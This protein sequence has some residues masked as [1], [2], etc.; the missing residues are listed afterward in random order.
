MA[1][2]RAPTPRAPLPG[3]SAARMK[4]RLS[5]CSRGRRTRAA[6]V[7]AIRSGACARASRM[8]AKR[9]A[10]AASGTRGP[11]EQSLD[12][13]GR[14][15]LGGTFAAAGDESPGCARKA[16]GPLE[17]PLLQEPVAEGAAEAV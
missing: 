14:R 1:M 12:L 8:P 10:R 15:H 7:S 16:D 11:G 5:P 4:R 17:A 9:A 2:S 6:R 13:G 3:W